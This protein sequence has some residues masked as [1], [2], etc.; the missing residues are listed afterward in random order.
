MSA[1]L[2]LVGEV[3][4]PSVLDTITFISRNRYHDEESGSVY[5]LMRAALAVACGET[6]QVYTQWIEQVDENQIP[7]GMFMLCE[8]PITRIDHEW[9][10]K[11]TEQLQEWHK[12]YL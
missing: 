12:R 8:N 2:E 7:E 10:A 9:A 11:V 6:G 4:E 3:G 1:N 5:A